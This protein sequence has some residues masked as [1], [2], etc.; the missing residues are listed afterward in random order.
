MSYRIE[1][2][3]IKSKYFPKLKKKTQVI[4]L[5]KKVPK[6]KEE[7]L[8]EQYKN[9]SYSDRLALIEL[10][11]MARKEAEKIRKRFAGTIGRKGAGELTE[12]VKELKELTNQQRDINEKIK[13][14]EDAGKRVPRSLR[15]EEGDVVAKSMR[16][17][18]VALT[19]SAEPLA[20]SIDETRKKYAKLVRDFDDIPKGSEREREAQNE[21]SKVG[22][23]SESLSEQ[24]ATI[25]EE[26][27]QLPPLTTRELRPKQKGSQGSIS[28]DTPSEANLSEEREVLPRL[29]SFLEETRAEAKEDVKKR[30][31]GRPRKEAQ[32][33]ESSPAESV[34]LSQAEGE[35]EREY[36]PL[37]FV[38]GDIEGSGLPVKHKKILKKFMKAH[39]NK[40][41]DVRMAC[42]FLTELDGMR[43]GKKKAPKQI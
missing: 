38:E 16:L 33:P 11:K 15:D 18:R 10:T 21:I 43:K 19:H 42:N 37:T 17:R 4:K 35:P 13:K 8:A 30:R 5:V 6:S 20:R 22:R 32:T 36:A 40:A 31:R 25:E 27:R 41:D 29:S 34:Y 9:L 7:Q 14:Y 3:A 1:E 2:K 26:I 28:I 12:E 23:L 39:S 24:L